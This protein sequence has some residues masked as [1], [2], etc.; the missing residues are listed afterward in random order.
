MAGT[1]AA[2]RYAKAILEVSNAKGKAEVVKSD[3]NDIVNAISESKEL[4]DFIGNPVIKGEVKLAALLEVFAG[5]DEDT[6][7]LF[8]LLLQNKR[9]DI[10]NAIAKQYNVL[11]DEFAG[12]EVAYVTTAVPMTPELETKVLSKIKQLSSKSVTIVNKVNPDII[13]GF[14]IRIGDQQFNAS[15]ADKLS[16]LKREFTN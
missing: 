10:L 2:I 14:I 4:N 15:V 13:G 3:M 7:A 11:Y 8:H 1:R 5:A 12:V 16:Q 9:F 6:K